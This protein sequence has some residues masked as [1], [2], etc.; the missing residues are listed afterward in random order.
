VADL[1]PFQYDALL[2]RNVNISPEQQYALTKVRY[3]LTYSNANTSPHSRC[4]QVF[5][6]TSESYGHGNNKT[7]KTN[8]TI[9]HPYLKT[10]PRVP[11]VQLIGNG[12]VLIVITRALKS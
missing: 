2:F 8:K 7:E 10:I 6:P 9:L 1:I 12:M 5:D 3:T 4:P 11:Q